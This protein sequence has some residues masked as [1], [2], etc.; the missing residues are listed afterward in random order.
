MS[1]LKKSYPLLIL[2]RGQNCLLG[3]LW[4][5]RFYQNK[6]DQSSEFSERKK[7]DSLQEFLEPAVTTDWPQLTWTAKR[8]FVNILRPQAHTMPTWEIVPVQSNMVKLYAKLLEYLKSIK[9]KVPINKKI[10]PHLNAVID[11]RDRW[12]VSHL[13]TK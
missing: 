2:K 1:E 11:C 8:N 13:Q 7:K 4:S 9:W 12:V 5:I 6:T 3:G 10:R